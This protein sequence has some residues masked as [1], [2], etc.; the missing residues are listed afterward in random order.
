MIKSSGFRNHRKR[1][2]AKINYRER[3]TFFDN[4]YIGVFG[5]RIGNDYFDSYDY[6]R[7]KSKNIRYGGRKRIY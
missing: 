3:A 1:S 6:K 2:H 7:G 5:G 4:G